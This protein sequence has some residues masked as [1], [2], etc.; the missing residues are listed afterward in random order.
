MNQSPLL[1]RACAAI[2]TRAHPVRGAG[3]IDW[4]LELKCPALKFRQATESN[5]AAFAEISFLGYKTATPP[6]TVDMPHRNDHHREA[7]A[8]PLET[9]RRIP[10]NTAGAA[11]SD[12]A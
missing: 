10:V 9:P 3:V 12:T 7:D 5:I 6:K 2:G 11:A 4:E 1:C 8:G